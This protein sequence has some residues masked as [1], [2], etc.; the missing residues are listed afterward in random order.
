M[1]LS[2]LPGKV[3]HIHFVEELLMDKTTPLA[4]SCKQAFLS[5]TSLIHLD[6]CLAYFKAWLL[7]FGLELLGPI[8]YWWYWWWLFNDE[9][10]EL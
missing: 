7:A 9:S 1:P 3:A 8:E 5:S 6:V 2:I 10:I 4:T